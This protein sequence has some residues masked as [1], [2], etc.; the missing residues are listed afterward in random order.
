MKTFEVI[1][2]LLKNRNISQKELA[3]KI[4][5]SE[6]AISQLLTGKYNFSENTL[7]L[8]SEFLDVPVPV[9]NFLALEESDVPIHKIEIYRALNP[10]V[11]DLLNEVFEFK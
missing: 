10:S 9:L 6:T 2:S 3:K 4:G 11:T 8:I 5:K 7:K 1:N